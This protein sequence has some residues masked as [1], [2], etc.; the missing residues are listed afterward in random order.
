MSGGCVR[1]EGGGK[2]DRPAQTCPNFLSSQGKGSSSHSVNKT[3]ELHS[4]EPEP[5]SWPSWPSPVS[6]SPA[7]RDESKQN[8]C[9]QKQ[10]ERG[11]ALVCGW[12][13]GSS[14]IYLPWSSAQPFLSPSWSFPILRIPEALLRQTVGSFV[15]HLSILHLPYA[16]I[17]G[18]KTDWNQKGPQGRYCECRQKRLSP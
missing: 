8:G 13:E 2:E 15:H 14:S 7:Y 17:S 16:F 18:L 10:T 6:P 9:V 11:S 1:C 5:H 3:Q 12:M 4:P